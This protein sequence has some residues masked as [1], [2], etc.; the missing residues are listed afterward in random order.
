MSSTIA[1][2][3]KRINRM[4]QSIRMASPE[5][6]PG[7]QINLR[8]NIEKAIAALL[9]LQNADGGIPAVAAHHD[10]GCWTTANV[11]YDLLGVQL[12]PST[13]FRPLYGMTHFLLKQQL[14]SPESERGSWPMSQGKRGSVMTTGHCCAALIATLKVFDTDDFLRPLVEAAIK[15]ALDWLGETQNT[16][17]GWGV[18]PSA[19]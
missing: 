18:E 17:G 11:I 9:S 8:P 6:S 13:G 2:R 14:V 7:A 12:I 19:M 15:R 10:S 4:A 1:R 16:D 3:W 5:L